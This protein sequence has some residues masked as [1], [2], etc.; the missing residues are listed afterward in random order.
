V[1]FENVEVAADADRPADAALPLIE[2]VVDEA[3]AATCADATGAMKVLVTR[4]SSTPSSASSS[5][6]RS[7]S[8][9][10]PAPH[11]RHVRQLRAGGVDH[12]DGDA[13]ARR[14]RD[15]AQEGGLGGEAEIGKAG[16]FV[17]QGAVQ[18]HGGM[19]MTDD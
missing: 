13:E 11:G 15:R 16:R 7:A 19:G 6:F 1:T 14:E 9:S 4:P 10:P 8:S 2:R 17:G 12:A 18:I 5:A 3:I